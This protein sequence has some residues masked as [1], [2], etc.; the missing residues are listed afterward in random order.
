MRAVKPV[1][2][3]D[4]ALIASNVPENDHSVWS[5]STSYA[6]GARVIRAHRIHESAVAGNIGHDPA[7]SSTQWIDVGP[8]NRWAMLVETAGPRTTF[9]GTIDVTLSMEAALDTLGLVDIDATTVRVRVLNGAA[10]VYDQS[11][12]VAGASVATFF[13]LPAVPGRQIRVTA[14]G[15]GQIAIGK[16]VAGVALD[17]GATEASP[18]ISLTDY[19]RRQTDDFGVTTVVERA[20]AKRISFRT[21]LDSGRVDPVQQQMAELRAKP[22]LWIGD[23]GQ[24]ALTLYGTYKDFAVDLQL[25]SASFASL[26]IEGLPSATGNLS[27]ID[28]APDGTSDLRVLRPMTVDDAALVASNVPETEHAQWA[29]GT[30]YGAG[31]KVIWLHRIYESL[32][33]GNVGNNPA[34]ATGKWLDIG[35]SNRWAMFDQALGSKT[36]SAGSIAV[37]IKA[38]GAISGLAAL[39]VAGAAVRVQAPGYDQTRAIGG[40]AQPTLAFLD[41]AVA[42]G[43]DITVTITGAASIGTL[44]LGGLEPLGVTENT[45]TVS[46]ADFSRKETDDFGNSSF[47]ERA[48]AKRMAVRSLIATDAADA[49]VRR[50][51]SLRAIPALWIAHD[52][53]DSLMIYGFFRDASVDIGAAVSQCAFTVEGLSTASGISRGLGWADIIDNDPTHPKPQDGATVGAPA[54]TTVGGKPAE[55][56]AGA[57]DQVTN[58]TTGLAAQAVRID[59]IIVDVGALEQAY[60]PTASAA[61]SAALAEASKLAAEDAQ[62]ASYGNATASAGSASL[63][64]AARDAASDYASAAEASVLAAEGH[65]GAASTSAGS[66]STSATTATDKAA[67]ATSAAN[68]AALLTSK[69]GQLATNPNFDMGTQ[70]WDTNC[71]PTSTWRGK[72]LLTLFDAYS[73]VGSD[74]FIPVSTNRSYRIQSQFWASHPDIVTYVGITCYDSN[75]TILGNIYSVLPGSAGN[76]SLSGI[77]NVSNYY[78]GQLYPSGTYGWG[79]SFI[80]GTVKVKLLFYYNYTNKTIPGETVYAELDSLYFEDATD[81]ANSKSFAEIAT[82]S[83][84]TATAQAALAQQSSM[85]AASVAT[86]SLNADATFQDITET[87]ALNKWHNWSLNGTRSRVSGLQP[88]S[89]ALRDTVAAGYDHGLLQDQEHFPNALGLREPSPGKY[90]ISLRAKL[91]SGSLSGSGILVYAMNSVGNWMGEPGRINAAT[92]PDV[93][94]TVAGAGVP[95]RTYFWQKMIEITPAMVASGGTLRLYQMGNW[96]DFDPAMPAKVMDWYECSIRAATPEEVRANTVIPALEATVNQQAGALATLQ[97]ENLAYLQ[98]TGGIGGATN[99]FVT[100]KARG[101][102]GEPASG[103]V[104]I[105]ADRISLWN[106]VGSGWIAALTVSGTNAVFSGGLQAGAYIRQG[107]GGGWPVALAQ[108]SYP[109]LDG[110]VV[111]FGTTLSNIPDIDFTTAGL[112]PLGTGEAYQLYAD[113]LT[114]TGFTARL[115]IIT[116]GTTTPQTQAGSTMPGSGPTM[117][118][119]KTNA[120]ISTFGQYTFV[121]GVQIANVNPY[122]TEPVPGGGAQCDYGGTVTVGLYVKRSGVWTRVGGQ[123]VSIQTSVFRSTQPYTTTLSKSVATTISL[124]T[125]PIEAFGVAY[126]SATVQTNAGAGAAAAT[127]TVYLF[128]RVDWSTSSSSTSRGATSSGTPVPVTVRPK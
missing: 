122:N 103:T 78:T 123:S 57:V 13:D 49:Q 124:G 121:F 77:N 80:A 89:F 21:R 60:G 75:N 113:G 117:Q 23:D 55:D 102:Y 64:V 20:W 53:F 94:G 40:G 71:I 16:L 106:Q 4:A 65:A 10:I 34:Q 38:S 36:A 116:P 66:A 51:A 22:V 19:S 99:W 101:A 73:V 88:G 115:K 28:P 112:D 29:A 5:A 85:L 2:V 67:E 108:Q 30:N 98:A 119:V 118:M 63:A 87:G 33:A 91:V 90:I 97:G 127:G 45:P 74:D 26:T 105:G 39:D 111:S 59:E 6:I 47:V 125:A 46:I 35:P 18:T 27:A 37:T 54:G 50:L 96:G 95:G 41:L 69:G 81:S 31:I 100:F 104:D 72:S 56:V 68:L 43:A 109:C 44:L 11:R 62:T 93:G 15:A 32:A 14:T 128:S 120:A 126:E 12:A 7:T 84:A 52:G 48:W 83:A 8:T 110:A 114:T 92:Y 25:G 107:S 61:H 58:P 70:G 3:T 82:T 76:H 17:I 9:A 24:G 86:N 1:P 42:T 79:T